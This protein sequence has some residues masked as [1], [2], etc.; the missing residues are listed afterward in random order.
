[1]STLTD[2]G[3]TEAQ[4]KELREKMREAAREAALHNGTIDGFGL[5]PEDREKYVGR[6]DKEIVHDAIA[7]IIEVAIRREVPAIS[8]AADIAE[9]AMENVSR[10]VAERVTEEEALLGPTAG[11]PLQ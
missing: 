11:A 7:A 8:V 2:L 4:E 10:R 6:S 9:G 5:T 1:M 3:L